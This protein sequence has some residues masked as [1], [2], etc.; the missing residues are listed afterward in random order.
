MVETSRAS[1]LSSGSVVIDDLRARLQ[2]DAR[3]PG[4]ERA[5]P[6]LRALQVLEDRD[7]AAEVARGGA[8]PVEHLGVI[9]VTPV[10]E[11]EA[12]HVDAGG[13]QPLQDF[14]V[15]RGGTEGGDYLGAAH[16]DIV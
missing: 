14:G 2:P 9:L 1:P 4:S 8:D 3:P 10:G 12:G 15:G 6:D 11:V 13:E 7:R 5:G 16:G